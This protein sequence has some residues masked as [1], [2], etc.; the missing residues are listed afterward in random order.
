MG[1][2]GCQ[3]GT[4]CRNRQREKRIGCGHALERKHAKNKGVARGW[5]RGLCTILMYGWERETLSFFILLL[6]HKIETYF[7]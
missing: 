5:S 3:K 1:D 2:V 4:T 6:Y 7:S